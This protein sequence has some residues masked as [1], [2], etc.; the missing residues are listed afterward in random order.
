[1]QFYQDIIS[2]MIVIVIIRFKKHGK[3]FQKN[4]TRY[5][6]S[7]QKMKHLKYYDNHEQ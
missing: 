5:R 2:Q 7:R 3:K 4:I 1:M 6:K